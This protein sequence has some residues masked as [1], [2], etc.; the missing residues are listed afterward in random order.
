MSRAPLHAAVRFWR[1]DALP[2]VEVRQSCYT[3]K[4]FRPHTHL[5][6]ILSL[7][8]AGHTRFTLGAGPQSQT[9]SASPGQLVAIGAGV[10]HA[11]NP[12]PGA[13]IRYRLLAIAPGRLADAHGAPLAFQRPVI[14]DAELFAALS[15]AHQAF[16]LG[17]PAAAKQALLD[18]GLALLARRHTLPQAAQPSG[19][20]AVLLARQTIDAAPGAFMA[21]PRL[22]D[23][24]GLSPHH[25]L[26]VFKAEAGLT[27]H[28]YQ[29]QRAI[30][31]GKTLLAAGTPICEAALACGFADQSHFS[32]LFRQFTGATPRQYVAAGRAA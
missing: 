18:T 22:A 9:H 20:P 27:P 32:R 21:L 12:E 15:R 28:A 5:C 19:H 25:F 17:L 13:E 2:G 30:E 1:D 14:D 3:A 6:H 10:P 31:H 7:V 24:G 29:L 4:A 8:D 16:V 11:C 23:L 26:R